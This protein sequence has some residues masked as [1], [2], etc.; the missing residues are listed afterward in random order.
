MSNSRTLGESRIRTEFNPSADGAVDQLKQ[1][2]AGLIDD[3]N[4]I[5]PKHNEQARVKN[6]ALT[7]IEEAAMWGVKALTFY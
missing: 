6:I 2:F 5:E 4:A 3:V 7:A 1:K